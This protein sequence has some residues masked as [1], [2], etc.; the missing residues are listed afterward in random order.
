MKQRARGGNSKQ[1]E[2]PKADR[3]MGAGRI[4]R[5]STGAKWSKPQKQQPAHMA[6]PR[7]HTES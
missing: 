7:R 1:V 6:S 2:Q 5:A 4:K 3:M